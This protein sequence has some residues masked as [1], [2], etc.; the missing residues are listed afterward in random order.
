MAYINTLLSDL[1][2]LEG[3]ANLQKEA[4]QTFEESGLPTTKHEEWKFTNLAK[5]FGKDFQHTN[6]KKLPLSTHF[7]AFDQYKVVIENGVFDAARSESIENNQLIIQDLTTALKEKSFAETKFNKDFATNPEVTVALNTALLN[8]GVYVKIKKNQT[9]AK[10][11]VIE[12]LLNANDINTAS[13]TRIIVEVEE[14]AEA[15]IITNTTTAGRL[16]TLSNTATAVTIGKN[17]RFSYICLQNDSV[18]AS[19]INNTTITQQ[20]NS[21]VDAVT[22]SLN[23]D[24]IR[25][26]LNFILADEY[27]E[28]NFSSLYLLNGKTHVDNHTV[29]DHQ[30][31]N[32]NSNE[33]YK[34]IMDD[35]SR[36]VFNGK[37]FVRKD[38]QKTNAFQANNNILLSDNAII[39]TKPQLE[40]WADDV[41]CSHGCTIGQ[42]DKEALFYLKSRGIG[43]TKA[44]ALLLESFAQ[45]VVNKIS[46]EPVKSYV[47]ELIAERLGNN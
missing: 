34:G 41:K 18:E 38:A 40:I 45:E 14:N 2:P 7:S 21:I 33:L 32:C 16:A 20:S 42:L 35:R 1:K 46:F 5:V 24:L 25:N 43:E 22:I 13:Y 44:K 28:S 9:I 39:N 27:I 19:Q 47:K 8:G 23:G 3:I 11:I 6:Y 37:I 31:P 15:T 4:K 17:A 10:P 12:Q 26:N 36:G 29:A 30:F